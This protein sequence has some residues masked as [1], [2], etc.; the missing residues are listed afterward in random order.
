MQCFE[1]RGITHFALLIEDCRDKGSHLHKPAYLACVINCIAAGFGY[2]LPQLMCLTVYFSMQRPLNQRTVTRNNSWFYLVGDFNI[3]Q[4]LKERIPQFSSQFYVRRRKDAFRI[5]A[6][7]IENNAQ[8]WMRNIEE[9]SSLV[10]I[11]RNMQRRLLQ[12]YLL[13]RQISIRACRRG[14]NDHTKATIN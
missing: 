4:P 5:R 9:L 1:F 2:V 11:R 14:W 13:Q 7:R 12:Q 6:F 8:P 10:T 3:C